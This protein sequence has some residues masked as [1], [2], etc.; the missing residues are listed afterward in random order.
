MSSNSDDPEEPGADPLERYRQKRAP[1]TPE[2]AG[3]RPVFGRPTNHG[4]F[5]V[6]EHHATRNHWDLRLEIDGVLVSWAVPH[7][8]SMDPEDKR[9][10]VKV[11]AHPLAYVDFEAVIPE[12]LYGAGPLIVWDRGRFMPKLDPRTGLRDGEVKFEL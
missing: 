11:E 1:G 3:V 12:K 8:P 10:A 2:P 5:V 9:L 6:H 7:G 4:V